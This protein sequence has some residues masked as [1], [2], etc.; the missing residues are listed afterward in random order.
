M[1]S[2]DAFSHRISRRGL[3]KG[4]GAAG[5]IGALGAAT[6]LIGGATASAVAGGP[7]SA[8][9]FPIKHVVICAE[10]NRSFDHYFGFAPWAG[11]FGVPAGYSQPDGKGGTVAPFHFTSFA[12]DDVPHSWSAMHSEWDNWRMDGFY[13]TGGMNTMG[14]Y[15]QADLPFYYSLFNQ[16]TLCANYFCS[17]LGPT[18]PNRLYLMSGTSGGLTNNN[19]TTKGQLDYPMILDLLDA[20]GVTWKIYNIDFESI[21]SGWSDNVAQFYARWQNDV[22]VLATKQ[23]YL[24]DLAAGTLPQVSWIIPDDLKGWDE[25]PPADIRVGMNLQ[26]EL[27]TALMKSRLWESS[28]YILTYDESGG[29]FDHVPPPQ[30]DAYGLGPRVPTWIISPHAKK[31]HLEPTI[32]EHSSTLKFL[33]TIFGLPTVASINHQFDKSTPATDNAA[34]GGAASGPPAPPR[35]GLQTIGDLTECFEF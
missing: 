1:T 19:L 34:A 9:D 30:L 26:Q 18:Y 22:R 29:F 4:I 8:G 23:D 25:H 20:H 13:T 32:Y 21:E 24:H 10:E 3:L 2:D 11:R 12:T 27:I 14:Y 31:H 16:F 28:A 6:P 35:D 5:A 33:E 7:E 17:Q 15:T